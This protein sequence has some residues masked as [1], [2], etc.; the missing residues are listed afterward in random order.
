MSGGRIRIALLLVHRA[1]CRSRG[2]ELKD[3]GDNL[4][5]GKTLFVEKCARVPHAGPRR[6]QGR[7]R[8]EPRPG[9][10]AVAR[11]RLR[12]LHDRG[13]RPPPD[14]VS[15]P[16]GAVR[17][18]DAASSCPACPPTS[19]RARTPRTSPPTWRRPPARAART[20]AASATAGQ[21]AEHQGRAG[22]GRDARHPD[23]RRPARSRT[24]TAA[25]RRQPGE[26]TIDSKN[27]ASIP[28]DIAVE[29]NGVDEKGEVVQD[30]GTSTL[31]GRPQARRLHVLLLRARP[32]RGRHGGQAHRQVGARG[33]V[34]ACFASA[35]TSRSCWRAACQ[36]KKASAKTM[37][38]MSTPTMIAP[39]VCWSAIAL[40]PSRSPLP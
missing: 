39:A 7:Q 2:C 20:P 40:I 29:G 13:H 34:A 27:D 14:P 1:R 37:I 26:I 35:A 21:T 12:A 5:N 38:M 15:Q 23:R 18:A 25:P 30:G 22:A 6:D 3:D 4:V 24:S 28:H 11:G 8:P 16:D 32:P 19:S 31:E 10:P 36:K 33:S 9:V 17:P